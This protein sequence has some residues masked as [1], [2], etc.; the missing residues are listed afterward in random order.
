MSPEELQAREQILAETYVEAR[1][2]LE[3]LDLDAAAA[4]QRRLSYEARHALSLLHE[5]RYTE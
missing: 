2:I 4:G 1:K 3:H 5:G